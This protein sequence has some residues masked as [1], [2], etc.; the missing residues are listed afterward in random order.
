MA[1]YCTTSDLYDFGLPRGGIPNPARLAADPPASA[2]TNAIELDGHGFAT[3]DPVSFRAEAG[4]SLPAPL[5]AGTIY[6]AIPLSEGYFSVAETAGGA[7][8]DLTTAG[9]AV[10]VHTPLPVDAAIE[11]ASALI[12]DML[13]AHVVPLTAPYP[14]IV[15]MSCAELAAAKLA[16]RS[17]AASVSL[18]AM[19]DAARKRLERWG[20]G[21]PLRGTNVSAQTPANLAQSA[22]APALDVRGFRRWGGT[23]DGGGSCGC[24]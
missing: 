14:P 5:V 9:S 18:T 15:V 11:F 3:D 2:S 8:I 20:Q 24:P 4:G 22:T 13:P 21:I 23:G 16:A 19:A 17:G 7:A 12:D 6:Y 10:V 1:N